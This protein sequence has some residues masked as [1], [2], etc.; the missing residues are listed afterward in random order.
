MSFRHYRPALFLFLLFLLAGPLTVTLA[1]LHDDLHAAD[2]GV[3]LGS[4]VDNDGAP[5]PSLQARLD[6]AAD[7]YRQGYFK[8]ILVSGGLERKGYDEPA[9]MR[10][11]LEAHGVPH[12][13]IFED[14]D[15][16]TTW[17]TAEDTARFLNQ[18]HLRSVLIVSQYFHMPRC[19]L[20]FSKFDV[21]PIYSSHA[22]LWSLG[23]LYSVPR[24]VIGYPVYY[25]R[26]AHQSLSP[27]ASHERG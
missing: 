11:Y 22:R 26:N 6:H 16:Y 5:S 25:F 20:A 15:G 27:T 12:E 17:L 2:L 1:G 14:D 7:L 21:G 24:E 9:V 4:K 13:A 8:R 18:H 23:D 19:R 3:V 10:S